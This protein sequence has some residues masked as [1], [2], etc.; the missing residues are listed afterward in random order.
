M[1]QEYV[2]KA[3]LAKSSIAN[4]VATQTTLPKPATRTQG[5]IDHTCGGM[6]EAS[7]KVKLPMPQTANGQYCCHAFSCGHAMP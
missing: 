5:V 1:Q 7:K 4:F 6:N 2:S 3:N